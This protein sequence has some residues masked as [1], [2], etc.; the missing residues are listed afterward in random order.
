[1]EYIQRGFNLFR[2]RISHRSLAGIF[3]REFL[4]YLDKKE[5]E[6][7][8]VRTESIKREGAKEMLNCTMATNPILFKLLTQNQHKVYNDN[9]KQ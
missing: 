3:S 9:K 7:E 8:N 6:S 1:M 4:V 5:V 2:F